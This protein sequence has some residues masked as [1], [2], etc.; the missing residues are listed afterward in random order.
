MDTVRR[1]IPNLDSVSLAEGKDTLRESSL[2]EFRRNAQEMETRVKEAEKHFLEAQAGQSEAG[3]EDARKELQQIQADQLANLRRLT[4]AS[5]AQIT[6]L[7]ADQ[8]SRPLRQRWEGLR[9]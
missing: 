8:G 4:A 6:A 7:A 1:L 3:Q 9:A 2:A 5:Q